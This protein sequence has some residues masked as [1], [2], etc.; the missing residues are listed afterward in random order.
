MI[1]TETSIIIESILAYWVFLIVL[2]I[3]RYVY[4]KWNKKIL[5]QN[6][7]IDF[8]ML[9]ILDILIRYLK[10][11]IT[12]IILLLSFIAIRERIIF[13]SNTLKYYFT[14]FWFLCI[15]LIAEVIVILIQV[16]Y[17]LKI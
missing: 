3:A 2:L 7:I 8:L 16:S 10:L 15:W 6:L 5:I 17:A 12:Y 1:H 14:E 4:Y 13:K 11:E 9:F